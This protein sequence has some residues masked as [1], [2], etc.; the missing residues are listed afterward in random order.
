MASPLSELT[1]KNVRFHWSEV[2]QIAFER[3]KERSTTAPVLGLPSVEGEYILFAN[4]VSDTVIG[5]VLSKKQN[6]VERVLAFGRRLLSYAEKNY[7]ETRR[8]LLAG[9]YFAKYYRAYLLA[10][11]FL[12]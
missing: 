10:K 4:N 6:I 12:L 2:Q 11:R 1:K 8:E 7:R 3:L 9:V 5:A